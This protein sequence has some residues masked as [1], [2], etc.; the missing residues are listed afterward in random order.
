MNLHTLLRPLLAVCTVIALPS[1]VSIPGEYGGGG[2][3]GSSYGG[4]GYGGS[5]YDDDPGY[6]SYQSRPSSYGG[7]GGGYYGSGY[8]RNSS[9][10]NSYYGGGSR[11]DDNHDGHDHDSNHRSSNSSRSR[12]SSSNRSRSNDGDIRL[13]K[14]RD[15]TRGNIP[16]GYHSKE[17]YQNRG[18]SVSKNTY[19]TRDG[20]RRGYSGN[21]SKSKSK[22]KKKKD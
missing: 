4:G 17:W 2:Y 21:S 7:G 18:I 12:S 19:E 15:G 22:S 14:V 11:Y 1:C 3:G 16:E 20:D 9:Y 8:S 6:S 5:S 10:G 13:V